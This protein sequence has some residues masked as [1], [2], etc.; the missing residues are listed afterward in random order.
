MSRGGEGGGEQG[1]GE[2]GCW[3]NEARGGG[4]GEAGWDGGGGSGKEGN[5]T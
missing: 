3:S 2:G 5:M 4:R 1:R